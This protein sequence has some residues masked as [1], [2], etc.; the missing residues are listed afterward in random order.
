M[1]LYPH[2]RN[3]VQ[4]LIKT[5]YRTIEKRMV[6]LDTIDICE[7]VCN[8]QSMSRYRMCQY[9]LWMVDEIEKWDSKKAGRWI[10]WVIDR[11]E[12][13]GFMT[14]EE[15]RQMIRVDKETGNE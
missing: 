5:A 3:Q 7:M 11:M 8:D 14:N 15:S 10:G 12:V 9:L 6:D 1:P 2:T 13:M 4:V